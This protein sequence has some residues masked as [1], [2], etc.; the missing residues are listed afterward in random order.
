M[1][2]LRFSAV[3]DG[4]R[5]HYR[6]NA[7]GALPPN[8]IKP[9]IAIN[10]LMKKK[11]ILAALCLQTSLALGQT[12][13]DQRYNAAL[14]LARAG[15]TD[16]AIEQLQQLVKSHPE[17][18]RYLFDYLQILSWA[19]RDE[20]VIQQSTKIEVQTAPVYVLEAIA[21]AARYLGDFKKSEILYS[22]AIEKEPKRLSPR[23]GLGLLL[24]DLGQADSAIAYLQ[25]LAST[26]PNEVE[27][28]M[29]QAYA[30]ELAGQYPTAIQYYQKVLSLQSGRQ[31]AL[32]GLILALARSGEVQKALDLATANK[33]LFSDDQWAS[34]QWDYAAWLIRQGE[35]ALQTKPRDYRGIDKAITALNSNISAVQKLKL[36]DPQALLARA[37][38]DLLVALRDR[39]R[40]TDVV[41]LHQQL[42][43]QG[44][45]IP[46]YARMAAADAYLNN[47][48]PETARDLYLSVI[49]EQ[50]N[51]F[52]ARASLVYAYLEAE[53]ID[54]ALAL[55]EQLAQ[56]QPAKLEFKQPNG[57]VVTRD[58][59]KKISADLTAAILRAYADDLD[60]AQQKLEQLHNQYPDNTDIHSKLA[61]VYYFRG[62]PR[63]ARQQINLAQIKAPEHLGLKLTQAKVQRELKDYRAEA[64]TTYALNENIPEDS[65][66]QKQ[67]RAWQVRNDRELKVLA[68]GGLSD[69]AKNGASP[70]LGTD[71]ITV[72]GF[73]YSSPIAENYRVFTHDGW[74]TGSFKE[75]RRYLRHY[76][77]GLEYSGHSTTATA[78]VHYDNFSD[79]VVGLDL[80]LEYQ[81][82]DNWQVFSRLSSRDN[83]ISLRALN[84][85]VDKRDK[86]DNTKIYERYNAI[87]AKSAML[88]TT[89]KVNESRFF[90]VAS[91]YYNFS[92]GNNR[93]GI[94]GT[95][96][97]RWISG[98]VYKL[99]TYVNTGFSANTR[100]KFLFPDG[101]YGSSAYYSPDKDASVSFTLDNDFL[102]YR[103]YE[104]A[105]HQKLALSVGNYWQQ[106]YGSNIVG[107][108]QYEHRWQVANR[109][110]LSYGG[111]RGY[112][113][114]DD[115]LTKNWFM[116]L[117]ADL[118]F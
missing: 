7:Y 5:L 113:Y 8:K 95:Y 110:E 41:E 25:T 81:L 26:Y 9:P 78:E 27:I 105:F 22:K 12:S 109:F 94:D 14:E 92:D 6:S 82:N 104:T 103:H 88:G 28:I 37:K 96:F 32:R 114:Y 89:Y 47:R 54:K 17:I 57:S 50:P 118:R 45:A 62:W 48:E 83:E 107:N 49:A 67:M 51:Y 108:V 90:T 13:D 46:V 70:V 15:H 115:G 68:N 52:N 34:L 38:F 66:V 73:L 74:K 40:M 61:E 23:L 76:G 10:S 35:Q 100:N 39:K 117:T 97:E 16:Q 31:D 69:N 24:I 93:Y 64:R 1:G 3:F 91:R 72:D 56:E 63:K 33:A 86:N 80:G 77:A 59:P 11:S 58:N 112:H 30:H 106:N 36:T 19:D 43:Q 102:T 65:G 4:Y 55:A 18:Q 44:L 60:G 53:Q 87:T 75:G 111:V 21:K 85:V 20:E 2:L 71:E 98:P 84:G 42:Q 99:A 79:E 101:E 29:A 116:Y